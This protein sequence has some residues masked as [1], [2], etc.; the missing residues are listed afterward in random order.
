MNDI[1][2]PTDFSDCAL[3][4]SIYGIHLAKALDKDIKFMHVY[5]IPSIDPN[6]PPEMVDEMVTEDE[7]R[8]QEE[9]EVFKSK[10]QPYLKDVTTMVRYNLRQGFAVDEIARSAKE[11]NATMVVMG[12]H[13]ASGIK[14]I[15][16]SNAANVI[17]RCSFPVMAIPE[18][19]RYEGINDIVYATDLKTDDHQY[20]DQLLF[21]A[22]RMS[23]RITLLHISKPGDE[24]NEVQLENIKTYF[25]K[26]LA[27]EHIDFDVISDKDAEKA[28]EGYLDANPCDLLALLTRR[29]NIIERVFKKSLTRR[30]AFHPHTPLLAFHS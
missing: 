11:L 19:A 14:Q 29:R 9:F 5:H 2:I 20:I 28:I 25:W 22:D 7:K 6:M 12:T 26:E 3:N 15:L 23:A 30:L 24:P 4:A 13:G 27:M 8:S 1:L 18:E 16:G 21:L 10:L 17:E